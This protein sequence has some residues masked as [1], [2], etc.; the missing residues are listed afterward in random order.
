MGA[1]RKASSASNGVVFGAAL[2]ACSESPGLGE[3]LL[4]AEW[5][6]WFW[7]ESWKDPSEVA[8]DATGKHRGPQDPSLALSVGILS[9]STEVSC[10]SLASLSLW[11]K[12]RAPLQVPAAA[13]N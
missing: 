1:E 10:G 11:A 12:M 5:K 2:A 9:V 13:G 4:G 8:Q 3:R 6:R 7:I